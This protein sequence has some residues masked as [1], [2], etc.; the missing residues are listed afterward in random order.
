MSKTFLHCVAAASFL[1]A[2]SARAQQL[3]VPR[4]S[5]TA[6]LTQTVGVT[7]ITVE[8]SSPGVKNR[9]IWGAVVPYN[10]VW[11][12]GANAATKMTFSRDVSIGDTK[13]AAGSYAF[14]AIP[15]ATKWTLILSKE[16]NQ[17]GAF[18]YKKEQDLLRLDVRPQVIA[19]RERLAYL[20]SN[21]SETAAQI[22]LEWEKVRVS[23][24]VKLNTGEQVATSIKNLESNGWGPWTSAA[25][26][27][28]DKK[29]YDDGLRLVEKSI[30]IK[31]TW[32]NNFTKAQ[33]L[34]GRGNT[35]D[36]YTLALK[37]K[38]MGEAEGQGF[39]LK[40]AVETALKAWRPKS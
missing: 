15:T 20:V 34:A 18:A 4:P 8:Y 12:T 1:V 40:D 26:Y 35:K 32:L 29:N 24:P 16:A 7:D 22:D 13:V 9:K 31:E 37:A 25:R 27:E 19:P 17:S 11:R 28:L 3:E 23:L 5:P 21:F 14:F 36:A 38:Q 10:E 30:G 39:F 33:L 2:G 6:K